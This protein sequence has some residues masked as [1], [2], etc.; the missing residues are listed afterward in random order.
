M[1]VTCGSGTTSFVAEQWGRR[2]ITCDTSRV[3]MAL[4]KQRLMTA[5]FDYYELAH[6]NEGVKSGFKY[7]TAS[8]I[9]LHSLAKNE[10]PQHEILYDQPLVDKSKVRVA[11]PFTVEAIP[12]PVAEDPTQPKSPSVESSTGR[13]SDPG[14][15]H[16]T[17][18]IEL[19]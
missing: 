13:P 18:M 17:D 1:D 15:D 10:P 14:G 9:T 4:A 6:P 16:V 3:A 5:V 2:W 19:L 7:K 12:I 8:H 11:G